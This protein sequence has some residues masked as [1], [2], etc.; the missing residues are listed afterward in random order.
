MTHGY[1]KFSMLI[2]IIAAS[3]MVLGNLFGLAQTNIKRMLAYSSIAHA[4]YMLIGIAAGKSLGQ[5]GILFYL[6][7]YMFT[8]IGAFGVIALLEKERGEF[9]SYTDYAGLSSRKPLL[10]GLFALFMFTLI[11][12]PPFSGFIGKYYLFA[13]AVQAHMTWLAVL[14]VVTSLI[15]TY[16]YLRVVVVMYFNEP[17]D[18][19]PDT[20]PLPAMIT[21]VIAA[22]C[23][24][25][26]GILPSIILNVTKALF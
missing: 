7:S 26:L 19:Q 17:G 18:L 21:L 1:E 13:S 24:T 15:S 10:T 12:I 14:G 8:N 23:I 22:A 3:S 9:T 11:G 20:V 6:V 4:G 16:Y 25:V 2:A 5:Q